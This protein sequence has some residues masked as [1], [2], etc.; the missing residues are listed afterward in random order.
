MRP[1][2]WAMRSRFRFA[3]VRVG[4][5]PLVVVGLTLAFGS[6]STGRVMALGIAVFAIVFLA[7]AFI[8][9]PRS[10]RNQPGQHGGRPNPSVDNP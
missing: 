10:R 7:E 5:G 1:S 9:Y 2:E 8:W 6:L 4:L 3:L